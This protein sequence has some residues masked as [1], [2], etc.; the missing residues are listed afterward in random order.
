MGDRTWFLISFKIEHAN[1]FAEVLSFDST[2]NFTEWGSNFTIKDNIVTLDFEEM[3]YGGVGECD[4]LAA[5]FLTFNGQYGSG[6]GY[7]PGRFTCF[8]GDMLTVE[9]NQ[10]MKHIAN[11]KIENGKVSADE[12]SIAFLQKFIDIDELV[13]K[14]FSG[15]KDPDFIAEMA[16]R[17]LTR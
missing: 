7:G 3:N 15:C 4:D 14:Y 1:K 10:D 16:K 13:K 2:K 6:G 9:T 17:R 5:K 8:M 11:I 12:D